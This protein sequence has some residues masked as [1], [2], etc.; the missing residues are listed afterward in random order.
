MSIFKPVERSLYEV[1]IYNEPSVIQSTPSPIIEIPES[2]V[3]KT[4]KI[5]KA[6]IPKKGKGK[7]FWSPEEKAFAIEKAKL[8]GL[9]KAARVLQNDYCN[10]YGDL[11]PSTLQYWVS[12]DKENISH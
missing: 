9:S 8:I 2:R 10:I 12:R 11:S 7:R 5:V 6:I 3:I 4:P 1:I